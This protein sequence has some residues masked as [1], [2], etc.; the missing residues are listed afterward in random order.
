MKRCIASLLGLMVSAA[1]SSAGAH[2]PNGEH[3]DAPRTPTA[4]GLAR[5]PDGSVNVPMLAQR[6]LG[7]RTVLAVEGEAAA[8]V[9]LP[10]RVVT[11]PNASG[12][13][14]TVVGGKVIPGPNGLPVPGQTVRRGD[15]LGYVVH[16]ADPLALAGQQALLTEIRTGRQLAEQ[17]VQRL[18][19]LEGT[20]PRKDI[21]A[22]RAELASLADRE[23]S[24]G[25][26]LDAREPLVA[27]VSGVVAR[28]DVAIGQVVESRELLFEV[29][30]PARLLVEASAPDAS[31]STQLS[32]ATLAGLPGWTL[33][34]IGAGRALRDGAVPL[35]FRATGPKHVPLAIGQ[36]VTVVAALGTKVTGYVLPAEAIT[37]NPSNEPVVWMKSGAERYI[38]QPVRYQPLD[39][40]TVVVT[41]GLGA[42][43][44]VVVQGASLIAQIR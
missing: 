41:A 39:A 19:S 9:E 5:L 27:P 40:R 42:D 35:T 20:V 21:E 25:A 1:L 2:G 13:V 17:R 31:L 15:V 16:H 34:F 24:I 4:D 8:T 3:L 33:Q 7:V 26:S 32:R 12:R 6:R 44:R 37:R 36:P 38:P 18:E 43:N 14:Q 11:D 23:K 22:A 29:I 10:A 30:D 28:A